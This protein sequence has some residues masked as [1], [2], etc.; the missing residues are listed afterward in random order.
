MDKKEETTLRSL[1]FL[2]ILEEIAQIGKPVTPTEVNKALGLPKQTLHRMFTTLEDVGFLQREID[3]RSYSPGARMRS[4]AIKTI[5]S[6]RIRSARLA[7]MQKLSDRVKETVNLAIPDRDCMI[8]LDRI[9]SDWPLRIQLPIGT[10]VP[11]HCTATGKLYLSTLTKQRLESLLNNLN[12]ESHTSKTII[13]P[14]ALKAE[15]RTIKKQGFA[16]DHEEFVDGMIAL[17]VPIF[18][19]TK[20]MT[21]ALSFHAPT[22][23]MDMSMA[24][25]HLDDLKNAAHELSILIQNNDET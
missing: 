2:L 16:S 21:A 17:A 11:F 22:Q 6:T 5:S 24:K 25:E 3:G 23:R 13:D 10:K 4:L 7:I 14:D 18:D 19:E 15:I 12:F 1:R 20:R 8:Y 9:E